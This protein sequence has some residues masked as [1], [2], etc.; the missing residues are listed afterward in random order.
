MLCSLVRSLA[1]SLTPSL[2]CG[3]VNNSIIIFA[4]FFSALDHSAHSDT[5]TPSTPPIFPIST[6]FSCLFLILYPAMPFNDNSSVLFPLSL[7]K[8]LPLDV[9]HPLHPQGFISAEN[10]D[11][12]TGPLARP[13]ARSLTLLTHL[14]APHCSLCSRALRR[15]FICSLAHS[16]PSSWEYA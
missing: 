6:F 8:Y 7:P 12:S 15:S 3:K 14:L 9:V 5:N 4:G 11:V 1:H 13:F 16:L 2:T 10:R